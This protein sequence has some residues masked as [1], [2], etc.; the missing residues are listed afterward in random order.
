MHASHSILFYL[1]FY[2]VGKNILCFNFNKKNPCSEADGVPSTALR[3]IS[4]LKELDHDSI[5]RLLDVVHADK[6]L[7][8][9]FEFLNQDLKKL[10]DTCRG[11]GLPLQLVRSYMYQLLEGIAF[12]HSHRILH[13]DLKPQ[14][15]LIDNK[16]TL[17][18]SV[19]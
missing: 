2:G 16:G 6:K 1:Y 9:V 3:E 18:I 7:Y 4:L 15:L 19:I 17:H 12:C 14:N 11:N 5:V 10:F 8:L 13:R